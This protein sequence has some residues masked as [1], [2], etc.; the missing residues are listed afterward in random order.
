MTSPLPRFEAVSRRRF[1][2]RSV[3]AAGGLA[4]TGLVAGCSKSD[5]QVFDQGTAAGAG[6]TAT[7]A[8]ASSSAPGS[9]AGPA[10][11]VSHTTVLPADPFP[12]GAELQLAF[13]YAAGGGG[14]VHNPYIAVWIE[15]PSG[16]L[17]QT[18][19]VWYSAREAKYLRELTRWYQAETT[20]ID[21]GGTDNVA[22]V[23]GATRN[24]GSYTVV[25]DG[26]DV[27]GN[28]VAKG[29]YVV[30]VESAREHGPHQLST[31]PVT[32]GTSAFSTTL[33]D[34]GELSALKVDFV[35]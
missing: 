11:T 2:Q 19:S 1:L 25:W 32:I 15:T 16:E 9:T 22:S 6:S 10:T 21:G 12:Q 17:V 14:Q 18:V 24:A 30:C 3:L 4:V 33:P 13:T 5:Q 34:S 35:V 8:A 27:D 7:T 31:G 28:P 29:D 26:T 20:L 23:S